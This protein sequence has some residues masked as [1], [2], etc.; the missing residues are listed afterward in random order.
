MRVRVCKHVCACLL[1]LLCSKAFVVIHVQL[2]L[3]GMR[4]YLSACLENVHL[5]V[6]LGPPVYMLAY[7]C[8]VLFTCVALCLC[9]YVCVCGV[10]LCL[11]LNYYVCI[12]VWGRECKGYSACGCVFACVFVCVSTSGL[13]MC[14]CSGMAWGYTSVLG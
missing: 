7:M 12:Y 5:R 1:Q 10:H 9:V 8:G 13:C 6:H 3:C 11:L 14:V 4:I 2:Y